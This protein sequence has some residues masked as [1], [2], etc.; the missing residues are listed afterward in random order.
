M[1]AQRSWTEFWRAQ[2]PEEEESTVQK[3]MTG[4]DQPREADGPEAKACP[5]ITC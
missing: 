4:Y 5:A 3:E 1:K 2:Y